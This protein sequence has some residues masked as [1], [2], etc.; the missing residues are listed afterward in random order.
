MDPPEGMSKHAHLGHTHP[1]QFASSHTYEVFWCCNMRGGDGLSRAYQY[2]HY[3]DG[4]T[5]IFPYFH[6]CKA[7]LQLKSGTLKLRQKANYP[8]SGTVRFT[9]EDCTAGS[10]SLKFFA[11]EAWTAADQSTVTLNGNPIE[12]S[13]ADGFIQVTVSLKADDEIVFDSPLQFFT[14]DSHECVNNSKQHFSFRHGPMMLGVKSKLEHA[15]AAEP[16]LSIARD[17]E[18]KPLGNAHYETTDTDGNPV[19]L[20]AMWGKENLGGPLDTFQILFA[21]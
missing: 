21:K 18:V 3:T 4:D 2:T 13:Y 10:V 9:V 17:A 5:A 6:A 16:T 7:T 1:T 15:K 11:P 12:T 20:Q 14:F 8:A 19:H